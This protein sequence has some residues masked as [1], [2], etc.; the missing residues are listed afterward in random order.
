MF[1]LNFIPARSLKKDG[2]GARKDWK[3]CV[4]LKKIISWQKISLLIRYADNRPLA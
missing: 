3:S 2:I 4:M 1:I